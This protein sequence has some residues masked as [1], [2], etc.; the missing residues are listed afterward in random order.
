[1]AIDHSSIFAPFFN[2]SGKNAGATD[3]SLLNVALTHQTTPAIPGEVRAE[4]ISINNAGADIPSAITASSITAIHSNTTDVPL[5]QGLVVG[6]EN[7]DPAGIVDQAYGMFIKSPVTVGSGG[8]A[9]TGNAGLFIQ[10]QTDFVGSGITNPFSIF[11]E[12]GDHFLAGNV[13]IGGILP[14]CALDVAGTTRISSTVVIGPSLGVNQASP[15]LIDF[16]TQSIGNINQ[17]RIGDNI[18]HSFNPLSGTNTGDFVGQK[19]NCQVSGV[20]AFFHDNRCIGTEI[21]MT[22]SRTTAVSNIVGL[23]VNADAT[24]NATRTNLTGIK[25]D[26][27]IS[28][29]GTLTQQRGISSHTGT[30]GACAVT[31]DSSMY[32]FTPSLLGGGTITNHYG[33]FMENQNVGTNQ[34]AIKTG[35]GKVELGGRVLQSKG[36]DVAAANDLTLGLDGN[37]FSITGNTQINAITTDNWIAGAHITLIF[38]GTPT[39]KHN[40]AG[41]AGTATLLLSGSADLVAANNTVLGLVYDG[42]NFQETFRKAA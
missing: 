30:S 5:V 35:L 6:V 33:L 26:T 28:G 24:N 4:T 15:F 42:T 16:E 34:W 23:Q 41:G 19:L 9:I 31:N 37:T 2:I 21:D 8:G 18:D 25:N 38:T 10:D 27:S 29:I 40:T 14:Q 12:G 17:T 7:N 13:G 36:A 1:M 3:T 20:A 32:I 39:V 22:Y 11:T